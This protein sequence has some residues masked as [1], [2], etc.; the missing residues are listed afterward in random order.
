MIVDCGF[1]KRNDVPYICVLFENLRKP[2]KRKPYGSQ[3]RVVRGVAQLVA[4]LFWVQKV[5]SSSLATPT[6]FSR[7]E[8]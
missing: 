6:K 8:V 3:R 5:A 7:E 2:M 1:A 4:C